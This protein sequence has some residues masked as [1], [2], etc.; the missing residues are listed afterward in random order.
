MHDSSPITTAVILA[1]GLGSRL[2][3]EWSRA[4]KGLLPVGATPILERS[5]QQL[6][7]HGIREIVLV[8]GHQAD[9]LTPLAGRYPAIR[10]VYNPCYATSG[11]MYSLYCARELLPGPFLLLESDLIYEDRALSALLASPEESALL[12]SGFTG[13]GDEVYVD[14][15][16]GRVCGLSKRRE[17]LTAVGGEMVGIT[18][19]A[20]RLFR[21]MVGH[22]EAIFAETLR[23]EYCSGCLNAVAAAAELACCKVDDLI[24]AEIDD[25]SHW[26]RVRETVFPR[27]LAAAQPVRNGQ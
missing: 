1:A 21:A 23:L 3:N 7:Q 22:A 26:Q 16:D 20:P 18:K 6:L 15:V 9:Q 27:L 5:L 14:V 25:A 12:V 11:S 10:T 2:Q 13:S 17:A 4:P 8:T 24:W 19:V